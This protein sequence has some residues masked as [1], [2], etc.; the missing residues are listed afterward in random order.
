MK[1]LGC[2]RATIHSWLKSGA[3][4]LARTLPNGYREIDD[5]SV[6]EATKRVYGPSG[7]ENKII[8]FKKGETPRIFSPGDSVTEK[9]V[10][11]LSRTA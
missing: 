3:L 9:V 4:R 11:F 6:Y 1:I 8:V 2:S 7:L 10:E 5:M